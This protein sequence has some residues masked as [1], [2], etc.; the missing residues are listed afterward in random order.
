M[1]FEKLKYYFWIILVN[2]LKKDFPEEISASLSKNFNILLILITSFNC[3]KASSSTYSIPIR[4][5][6]V[7]LG[8]SH[9]FLVRIRIPYRLD[10]FGGGDAQATKKLSRLPRGE[11]GR[12]RQPLDDNEVQNCSIKQSIWKWIHFSKFSKF[13]WPKN[14]IL[15]RIFRKAEGILQIF[16]QNCLRSRRNFWKGNENYWK[17]CRKSNRICGIIQDKQYLMN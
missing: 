4:H 13:F 7:T 9:S 15:L 12:G 8:P 10:F 6:N 3:I 16:Q 17:L 14:S 2:T 5:N 11:F 1:N